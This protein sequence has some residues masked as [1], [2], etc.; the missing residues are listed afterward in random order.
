MPSL[1]FVRR[2]I[3]AVVGF[4]LLVCLPLSASAQTNI[5]V[6]PGFEENKV[7]PDFGF[8]PVPGWYVPE[9]DSGIH[10]NV[11]DTKNDPNAIPPGHNGSL[12]AILFTALP[13]SSGKGSI[14][15]DLPTVVGQTYRFSFWLQ[16]VKISNFSNPP[17]PFDIFWGGQQIG[18]APIVS[19]PYQQFLYMV[20]ATSTTTRIQFE[21][22]MVEDSNAFLDDVS[23]IASSNPGP[24]TAPEPGT[25]ALLLLGGVGFGLGRKRKVAA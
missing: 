21:S 19:G 12:S 16:E 13:G 9:P 24:L 20:T 11:F 7:L 10:V 15:Q 17:A 4:G 2:A 18:T 8:Y 23:V 1:T 6:D 3:P 5:V 14:F 22:N 25:F